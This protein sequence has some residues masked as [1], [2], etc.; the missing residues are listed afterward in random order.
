MLVLIVGYYQFVC[1]DGQLLDFQFGQFIQVYFNYV[2]GIEIKCSY[3]LVIIYDYVLGLGEVVDIVVSFVFG[4]VVM[5]LFEVLEQGSQISVFGF[6]GWF[7]LNFG[8]YNVC[9]LLIVIGI[10]VILYC[11]MLLLLEKVMV[12]CGVQIVL[13][14]GVCS[15]GELLYS[16]DFYSF[17][18]KYLNF[19]YVLCL[20]C[21][22][23]VELY[24]DVQYGYVQQ[25]LVGFMLDL[26][27]DIVYLC[28]NLDMV[29]VCVELLKVVGLGN[30][31]ICCEKYVSS[32]QVWVVL[33]VGW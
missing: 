16:E 6:Y 8:D 28:G 29:D 17:V 26:V 33:V 23:L 7:C 19:C 21:E 25:V 12:E 5:V 10:G 24:L 13:L 18:E 32:K 14:Q 9:Y 15:F 4:G 31:Q 2:D 27:I 22:L 30:L 11:F 20:L 1:D 3:L